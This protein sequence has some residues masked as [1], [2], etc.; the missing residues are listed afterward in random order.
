MW[1]AR[2]V[3]RRASRV[4]GGRRDNAEIALAEKIDDAG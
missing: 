3:D 1:R 2:A 4:S